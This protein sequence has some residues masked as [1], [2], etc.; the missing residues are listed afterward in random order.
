MR[1]IRSSSERRSTSVTRSLGPFSRILPGS[2][3]RERCSSPAAMASSRTNAWSFSGDS[4]AGPPGA[5]TLSEVLTQVLGA[6]LL[7]KEVQGLHLD[8]ADPL[9]GYVELPANLFEG[10]GSVDRKS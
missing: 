3:R 2:I 4:S 10:T 9:P 7:T 6:S 5:G 1:E 8:L